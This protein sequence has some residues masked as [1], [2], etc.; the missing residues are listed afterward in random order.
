MRLRVRTRFTGALP[1]LI[2]ALPSAHGVAAWVRGADGI[3]GWG[4]SAGAAPSGPD[5]FGQARHW[6]RQLCV[7][8]EI[9]D[10]VR[11]PGSGLIA[12]AAFAFADEPGDS[13]LTVPAVVLGRSG[14]R[15]WRTTI[16][17]DGAEPAGEPEAEPVRD[18]GVVT[19]TGAA[20]PPE[21][22][23]ALVAAGVARIRAGHAEK[24]VLARDQYAEAE[25]DVDPRYLLHRLA[26]ANP[27]SWTYCVGGLVGATPELLLR[28]RDGTV[29][30]RVLAGTSFPGRAWTG[31]G[32]RAGLSGSAKDRAE[33]RYAV[34]SVLDRLAPHTVEL[35]APGEPVLLR[36]N[37]LAHLATDVRGTLRPG[38]P[39]LLDLVAELHPTAAVGGTPQAAALREIA[40]LEPMD[41]G[42]YA[43][44]VG[45]LDAGGDGE[46]GIAL[47]CA[48]LTG[49]RLRLYA[50][51]GVVAA[52]DPDVE[53]AEAEAKFRVLRTALTGADDRLPPAAQSMNGHDGRG[54]AMAVKATGT[55]TSSEAGTDLGFPHLAA[56]LERVRALIGGRIAAGDDRIHEPCGRL[57]RNNGRLFR[58]TLALTSAYP[59]A[60]D[61]PAPEGVIRAAAVVELLHV[62]TLYHDDVCDEAT[63]RRGEP[64]VNAQY[65]NTV[66]LLCGDYLLAVCTQL[67]S[68][69]GADA[70]LLFGETLRDLCRGQ[71]LETVDL[72]D[73]G[74][75][76]AA[77]FESIAGKTAKLMSSS[78][79]FGAMQAGATAQ[80]QKIMAGYGHH[81]GIAFQIWDDLL[82]VWSAHDTG[83]PRFVDL[84][85]GVYTLPVIYGLAQRPELAELLDGGPLSDERCARVSALLDEA[86]VRE[87]CLAQARTHITAALSSVGELGELAERFLPRLVGVARD[88]M[89]EVNQLLAAVMGKGNTP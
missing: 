59:F 61:G 68:D 18:P 73:L 56:D 34:R 88:L 82:D 30:S 65:G 70:M 63:A 47:R 1:G 87:L 77:Y 75:S 42:R 66:A 48:Q 53:A 39:D 67:L 31:D 36:L 23:R 78:A 58:P 57:I 27:A 41:R 60:P 7:R 19:F 37:A 44:P 17:P 79:A 84:R 85:N 86:G 50:G 12:F 2:G 25:H 71:F 74:R 76:E 8:A 29:E 26:G 49:R 11:V 89:P 45:W 80:E 16:T 10:E 28:R 51:C 40:A 62:A 35:D 43:G 6:W 9:D 21:K 3:V 81:L 72:G 32:S 46:F 64:T 38:A 4:E 5:R 55:D 14:D 24:I 13:R 54:T 20:V 52:S 83:K 69:L 22:Y 15:C 33:H